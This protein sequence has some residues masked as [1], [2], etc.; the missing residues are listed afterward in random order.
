MRKFA[1]TI[2][3]LLAC[4]L[5]LAGCGKSTEVVTNVTPTERRAAIYAAALGAF[6]DDAPKLSAPPSDAYVV[7]RTIEQA[8][9]GPNLD[10]APSQ[11]ISTS[12]QQALT[13]KMAGT[14]KLTWVPKQERVLVRSSKRPRPPSCH[15]VRGG[16]LVVTLDRL[17]KSGHRLEVSVSAIGHESSHDDCAAGWMRTYLVNG[18]GEDWQVAGMT[19]QKV[20]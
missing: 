11:Q 19:N 13:G 8:G 6:L 9:W 16:E 12:V 7:S 14:A 1:G 4:S 17:P 10:R 15:L 5:L 18:G 2:G 3:F 20:E